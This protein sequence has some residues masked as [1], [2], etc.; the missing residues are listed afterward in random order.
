MAR[1]QLYPSAIHAGNPALATTMPRKLLTPALVRKRQFGT[2][3]ISQGQV[4][5]VG[6]SFLEGCAETVSQTD[7]GV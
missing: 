7:Q 6:K 4:D 3:Q 2:R 1:V 5:C